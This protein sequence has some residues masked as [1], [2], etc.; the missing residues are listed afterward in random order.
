MVKDGRIEV[1]ELET[2]TKTAEA[3]P[4]ADPA[5]TDPAQTELV[6]EDSTDVTEPVTEP[7]AQTQEMASSEEGAEEETTETSET[8]T[9]D[10]EVTST[11]EKTTEE[12][13]TSSTQETVSEKE[14]TKVPEATTKQLET[15]KYTEPTTTQKETATP[16]AETTRYVEQTTVYEEPTS[17]V[18]ETIQV[19]PVSITATVKGTHYVGDTLR[20][21][22]FTV[23]VK[24]SD[25]STKTNPAGWGASPL[26]LS[27]ENTRINVAYENVSTTITVKAQ[28][29]PTTPQE[30][31]TVYVEPTTVYVEPTTVYIEPTTPELTTEE[32]TTVYVEPTTATP[33]TTAEPVTV[34]AVEADGRCKE[35][36]LYAFE[37]QNEI[38]VKAGKQPLVWNEE[39]YARACTCAKVC[40]DNGNIDHG[41]TGKWRQGGGSTMYWRDMTDEEY[42]AA[43]RSGELRSYQIVIS[44][45]LAMTYGGK[46]TW[47]EAVKT[48]A[49]KCIEAL[50]RSSGHYNQMVGDMYYYGAIGMYYD[51]SS[52]NWY[53]S[54][55]YNAPTNIENGE[56]YVSIVDKDTYIK[57][58]DHPLAD[59]WF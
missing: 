15:T 36:C 29:K 10:E 38:R 55:L 42:E 20:G 13:E 3:D 1:L 35:A 18:P 49:L 32:P 22:D 24:M 45:N 31:T 25:G 53:M 34:S 48:D 14:T 27:G 33:E 46:A 37:L 57:Y 41:Y 44:E 40:A 54:C 17:E 21:S 47:L 6:T 4:T 9:Q 52:R 23:T 30:T 7:D 8:T 56:N 39:L 28:V 12:E 5:Q 2:Y 43:T 58:W 51:N 11:E 16:A 59:P 50:E 19:V 26:Y